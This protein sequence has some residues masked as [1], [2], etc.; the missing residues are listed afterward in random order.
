MRIARLADSAFR[1]RCASCGA[2]TW[3]LESAPSL[4][5]HSGE[6]RQQDGGA[7]K[8]TLVRRLP[9]QRLLAE[10]LPAF[11][12]AWGIAETFYKWHSFSLEM[13]GFLATWAVLDAGIQ[14]LRRLFAGP[15]ERS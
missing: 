3:C 12:S 2:R 1:S 7:A 8:F 4:S 14:G 6:Q 15:S 10:H 11:A 9:G 13:L 5:V